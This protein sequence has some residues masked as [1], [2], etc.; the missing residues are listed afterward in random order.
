LKEEEIPEV[1]ALYDRY[2]RNY[3]IA[4]VLTEER[5]R[6][7]LKTV[8]GLSIDQ[9]MVARENGT[10]KA[11]S[12]LWDEHIYQSNQVLKLTPGIALVN[13]LIR[14]FG[15][16]IKMPHPIVL[17][18]PI[19]KLSLVFNAYDCPEAMDSLVRHI[20]NMNQGSE[21][22]MIMYYAQESD[23]VFKI[24]KKFPGVSVHSEMYAF[25]KDISVL[26]RLKENPSPVLSDISMML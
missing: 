25:A 4:P 5:F 10:I 17:G 24:L 2:S 23:P 6:N 11:V 9:F 15:H 7:L 20:N 3:K 19:R 12:A 16:V 1:V 26:D 8:E 21:F 13:S 22:S 18:E 14:F